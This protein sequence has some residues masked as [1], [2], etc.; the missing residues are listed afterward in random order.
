MHKYE[1]DLVQWPAHSSCTINISFFPV[2]HLWPVC[3]PTCLFGP[4]DSSPAAEQMLH[5][6]EC[7]EFEICHFGEYWG[8]KVGS[9]L[10]PLGH[11]PKDNRM[12]S[13]VNKTVREEE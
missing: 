3:D 8:H 1:K 9:I 6:S 12:R 13:R 5:S 11:L 10:R 2:S 4:P 7:D